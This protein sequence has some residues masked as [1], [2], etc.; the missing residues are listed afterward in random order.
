MVKVNY[1]NVVLSNFMH[2]KITSNNYIAENLHSSLVSKNAGV[3]LELTYIGKTN[4]FTL[5]KEAVSEGKVTEKGLRESAKRLFFNRMSLGEFDPPEIN[6]WTS[7][8]TD[9]KI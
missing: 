8:T 5:L 9:G 1:C 3:D 7:V 6:P 2:I 4:R